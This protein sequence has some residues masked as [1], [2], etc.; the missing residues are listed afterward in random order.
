MGAAVEAQDNRQGKGTTMTQKPQPQG[1]L[2]VCAHCLFAREDDGLAAGKGVVVTD[3]RDAAL[4]HARTCLAGRPDAAVTLGAFEHSEHC[5]EE[6]REEGCDCTWIDFSWSSCDGCGC[7][8][9]GEREAY[10]WW[11]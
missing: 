9:A 8:L 7:P 10:V 11:A 3:D 4:A 5:T 2:W 6:D 1:T